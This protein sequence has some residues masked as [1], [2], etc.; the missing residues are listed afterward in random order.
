MVKIADFGSA[1][2]KNRIQE[3]DIESVVNIGT[4]CYYC[5]EMWEGKLGKPS[6]VYDF[7]CVLYEMASNEMPSKEVMWRG[8]QKPAFQRKTM[9]G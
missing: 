7:G 5:P 1:I 2:F 6:D 4:S 8:L 9:Q 3:F